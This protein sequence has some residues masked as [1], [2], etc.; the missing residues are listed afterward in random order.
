MQKME[1]S[2]LV[3]QV[4]TLGLHIV[5]SYVAQ[6]STKAHDQWIT[7]ALFRSYAYSW[8]EIFTN[9]FCSL[10][11]LCSE[12]NENYVLTHRKNPHENQIKYST[13]RRTKLHEKELWNITKARVCH[14]LAKQ[15][16]AI[17]HCLISYSSVHYFEPPLHHKK[18][19]IN[20]LIKALA[21]P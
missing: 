18:S 14:C 1:N 20:H 3:Q 17:F 11:I 15:L 9:F 2:S 8:V 7:D 12:I 16:S 13:T 6:Y 21:V 10:Y 5:R 4:Y 19:S